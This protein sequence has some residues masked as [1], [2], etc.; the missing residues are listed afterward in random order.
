MELE[1]AGTDETEES[2]TL[3]QLLQRIDALETELT[4]VKEKQAED[5]LQP[6]WLPL[7]SAPPLLDFEHVT[8]LSDSRDGALR[9]RVGRRSGPRWR[10]C[11][12]AL[13]WFRGPAARVP[14]EGARR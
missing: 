14:G 5:E 4:D 13:R 8:L 7:L 11:S 6:Y 10:A 1:D 2:T 3:E 12:G 9:E